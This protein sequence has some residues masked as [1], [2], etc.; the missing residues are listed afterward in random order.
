MTVYNCL[1]CR[2]IHVGYYHFTK[3]RFSTIPVSGILPGCLLLFYRNYMYFLYYSVYCNNFG[4]LISCCV[5]ELHAKVCPHRNVWPEIVYCC[6]NIVYQIV[7][8][9]KVYYNVYHDYC[10]VFIETYVYTMFWSLC[11]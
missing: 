9:R 7:L 10:G 11:E 4:V 3:F 6:F 8:T 2:V 1:H 5:S